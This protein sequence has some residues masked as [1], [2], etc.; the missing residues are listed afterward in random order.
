MRAAAS[1]GPMKVLGEVM[2]SWEGTRWTFSLCHLFSCSQIRV[3]KQKRSSLAG[4]STYR[5]P[6]RGRGRRSRHDDNEYKPQGAR[7]CHGFGNDTRHRHWRA[8]LER[9]RERGFRRA[10]MV[11]KWT[12]PETLSRVRRS[13]ARPYRVDQADEEAGQPRRQ[14]EGIACRLEAVSWAALF[15]WV[16]DEMRCEMKL[17]VLKRKEKSTTAPSSRQL[18][19]PAQVHRENFECPADPRP[20]PSERLEDCTVTRRTFCWSWCKTPTTTSTAA[21]STPP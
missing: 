11:G 4:E 15:S 3:L 13:G 20:F 1:C 2:R 21:M 9:P 19:P 7:K 6:H 18:L 16:L 5:H 12:R 10:G 17:L 14:C 8:T